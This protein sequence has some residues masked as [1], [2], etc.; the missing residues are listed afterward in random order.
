MYNGG[1]VLELI[2][3]FCVVVAVSVPQ[4]HLKRLF[5]RG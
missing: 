4:Q 3:C 1:G 2:L 5:E